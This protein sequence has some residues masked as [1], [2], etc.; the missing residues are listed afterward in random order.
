MTKINFEDVNGTPRATG[1]EYLEGKSL[2]RA[3]ARSTTAQV[4]GKG[5]VQ[6]S[7]EVIVAGGAYNTPQLLKLS[8][9]G[10]ASE[11][12][13]F[14][15]PVVVDLPGVVCSLLLPT[16]PEEFNTDYRGRVPICKTDMKTQ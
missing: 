1:V 13:S 7:R 14:G 4:T 15:I 12:E 6:A 16:S 5:S 9:I 3:D 11:L 8:G 10:P 2:Y